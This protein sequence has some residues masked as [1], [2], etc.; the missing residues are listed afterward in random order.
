M[1]SVPVR[2]DVA[3]FAAAEKLTVPFPLPDAPAVIASHDVPLVAVHAQPV[4]ALTVTEPLEAAALIVADVADSVGAHVA[5][6]AKVFDTV[7]VADPPGP[8]AV[9]RAS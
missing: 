3:V 2:A 6:R 9:T 5:D 1:L 8:I 7:L 4:A